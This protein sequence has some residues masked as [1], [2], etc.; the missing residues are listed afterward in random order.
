M[1]RGGERDREGS[2]GGALLRV[3]STGYGNQLGNRV[4][5]VPVG[6]SEFSLLI[7]RLLSSAS[8]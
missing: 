3:R 2:R 7:D 8:S 4:T 6:S 1:E 5:R